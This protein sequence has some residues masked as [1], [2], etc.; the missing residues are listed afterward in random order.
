MPQYPNVFFDYLAGKRSSRS[1]IV[2]ATGFVLGALLTA[3]ALPAVFVGTLLRRGG[4]LI[5]VAYRK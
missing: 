5:A 3:L 2:N 1:K 4:T